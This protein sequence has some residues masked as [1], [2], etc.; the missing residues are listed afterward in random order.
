MIRT[1]PFSALQVIMYTSDEYAKMIRLFL[2]IFTACDSSTSSQPLRSK[3]Q[4]HACMHVVLLCLIVWAE[5]WKHYSMVAVII[6]AFTH[7][8]KSVVL[9]SPECMVER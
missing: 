5:P 7:V 8:H 4:V 3:Q 9:I 2:L 1:G 6:H